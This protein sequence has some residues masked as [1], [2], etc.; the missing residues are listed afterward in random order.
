MT[1]TLLATVAGGAASARAQEPA[2]RAGAQGGASASRASGARVAGEVVH[3]ASGAPLDGAMVA[4]LPA[5]GG[6]F[7]VN[8]V[9]ADARGAGG[10]RTGR[11]RTAG[12]RDAAPGAFLGAVRATR[13][14]A[15]GRYRFDDVPPGAYVLRV[16]R[17]GFRPTTVEV[18]L[19]G[20]AAAAARVSVGLTVAP[21]RLRAVEVAAEAPTQPFARHARTAPAVSEARLAAMRTRQRR[22]LSSDVREITQADVVEGVTLGETD[23]FR[24]LQRLGGVSTRN[25]FTAELWTRGAR[26]DRTRV[27]WDGLPLY[28]PLHVG[29]LLSAVNSD[30]VGAAFLHPGVR[31]ASVAEG[32]AAV[33]DLRSRAA[34]SD[35]DSTGSA[36]R[37]VAELSLLSARATLERRVAGGRGGWLVAGRRSYADVALP[38][39]TGAFGEVAR[40]PYHFDEVI[41]RGD[42]AAGAHAIEVSVLRSQDHLRDPDALVGVSGR[43]G[44]DV[45]RGRW[46]NALA[47]VA[48]AGPLRLGPLGTVAARH[49]VGASAYHGHLQH[50]RFGLVPDPFD[51]RAPARA[52][53]LD[54]LRAEVRFVALSG[55]YAPVAAADTARLAPPAWGVGWELAMQA[56]HTRGAARASYTLDVRD[57]AATRF[58][59]TLPHLALWG[60]RRLQPHARLTVSAGARAELGPMPGGAA[61]GAVRLVPRLTA[62]WA[63]DGRGTFV[64]AG[65]GR[66]VQYVQALVRDGHWSTPGIAL[67]RPV[68]LWLLAG[69]RLPGVDAPVPALRTDLLTLGAERW[70]GGAWHATLNA[71]ARRAAGLALPDPRPGAVLDDPFFVA[72]AER[73]VGL[74]AGVRRVVGRWTVAGSWAVARARLTAAGLAFPAPEDRRHVLG[75]TTMLRVHGGLRVGA[76]YSAFSGSPFTRS[77]PGGTLLVVGADTTITP[78]WRGAPGAGRLPAFARLDL[79]LDWSRQVRGARLGAY[80]QLHNA[81][82]RDNPAGFRTSGCEGS[83]WCWSDAGVEA[84]IPTVIP[85][86]GLR[87]GF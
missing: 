52:V 74:E 5:A 4:L 62:R 53:P 49:A 80:L 83:A 65:A 33:L 84:G 60:E 25:D 54:S 16:Q 32:S 66:S 59:A 79:L 42:W 2:T 63:V 18:D 3:A 41:A 87:L 12:A 17:L 50:R 82:L 72:G 48:V 85:L 61:G 46:G 21:V 26:W 55:E 28:N 39:V 58:G 86:V 45:V 78:P 56:A 7:G 10:E 23:L 1:A 40:F 24:A 36:L 38:L 76:A 29:G 51:P 77:N 37:G 68:P 71:Y 57:T 73:A 6:A 31:P 13:T 30:A 8:A 20:P 47:R 19:A 34:A 70:I 81:L 43:S 64:S 35:G 14:D 69:A 27:T 44:R 22:Y 9:G 11:D 67:D 15:A 75:A